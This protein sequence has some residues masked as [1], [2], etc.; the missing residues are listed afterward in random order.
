MAAFGRQNDP[1][2][3]ARIALR[4]HRYWAAVQGEPGQE[5]VIPLAGN[6]LNGQAEPIG[7]PR[8]LRD[9]TLLPP[10]VPSKIVAVGRNYADH[11]AEMGYPVAERP[12][13][14]FKPPSSLITHGQPIGYPSE[15]LEVQHEAELAVII[16]QPCRRVSPDDAMAFIFGYACANDVTARDIERAEGFSSYAKSFDTFCP[17]GPWITTDL[18]PTAVRITC[19]VN[20]QLRQDGNTRDLRWGI[21]EL[22]AHISAA[23]T[24]LPGDVVLTGTP[25]GVGPVRPGDEVAVTIK[26]IGTLRNPVV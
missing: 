26:G 15:S 25:A 6:V 14:F 21:P 7:D 23:M 13:I 8:R 9:I 22:I 11:V 18:D 10:V 3:I 5:V 17:L 2:R 12:K 16:G 20:G 4:E 1:M 24:L 19:T